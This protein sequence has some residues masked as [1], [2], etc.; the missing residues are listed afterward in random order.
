ML[1]T[2]NRLGVPHSYAIAYLAF[3]RLASLIMACMYSQLAISRAS[4]ILKDTQ[5]R[6]KKKSWE[7]Y[8]SVMFQM[9]VRQTLLSL[10]DVGFPKHCEPPLLSVLSEST[11][12]ITCQAMKK[13][14]LL[15]YSQTSHMGQNIY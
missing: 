12:I 5:K 11:D 14:H 9:R 2:S 6:K 15:P 7:T 8:S 4:C 1:S 3:A 10:F 13:D